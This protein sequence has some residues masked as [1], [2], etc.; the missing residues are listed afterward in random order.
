MNKL[1]RDKQVQVISLLAECS[2]IRSTE[3]I[4]GV[5]RDTIMR[6]LL[7]MGDACSDFMDAE[8]Q[9]LNCKKIEVDELWTFVAKKQGHL[10]DT[11]DETEKG[12]FWTF[13]AIDSDSK[14]VPVF[15]VGKRDA[16]TAN[17]FVMDLAK[18]LKN[19][20]QLSSDSLPAY[21]DAAE[22]AFGTEV[23][24]G[25][26][27]KWYKAEPI[28]AGRY[29]PPKVVSVGR[30]PISGK[31]TISKISTSYVERNNL[32]IRVFSKRFARL[33][34]AFSKKVD[35]LKAAI[36]LHFM[37]YNFVRIHR[38]LRATPAMVAGVSPR[39]WTVEDMV[40]LLD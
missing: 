17:A 25:Q 38:T 18:R 36:A 27:V 10:L 26:I 34:I 12:D 6:L 3:R 21:V 30:R 16:E 14:L 13:V 5:H 24:Y 20:V 37:Y 22:K 31:P 4:T 28:G 32:T 35:N 9:N 1:K 23:D 29:S 7:Q 2:S 15:R 8:M 11:D 33:S 39:L 40:G 19:R